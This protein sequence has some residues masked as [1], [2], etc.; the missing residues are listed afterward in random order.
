MPFSKFEPFDVGWGKQEKDNPWVRKTP[1]QHP[2][3]N[4]P[5]H[6]VL[7]PG[8]YTWKC[9]SCGEEQSFHVPLITL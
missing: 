3:H 2:E 6:M 1:C 8:E 7:S 5:S 4:P 9:P